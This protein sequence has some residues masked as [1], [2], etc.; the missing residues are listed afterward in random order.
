MVSE[1]WYK[2]AVIYCIDVDNFQDSDGDGCGDLVGLTSRLDYLARLGVTCLWLNPIHPSPQRDN[3]YDIS[4]YYAVD[5]RLGSLG[6]FV[7]LAIQARARGI[8]LLLD[9]VVNH[10]SDQHPW[11][12]SARSDPQSPYRDW[13]VWSSTEPA[14]RRQGMVFP[15]EQT[16][17]WTCDSV[18][19]QW[20]FHR[21]YDFQPDLNW[22][23]PAVRAEIKKVMAFWLQLGA[24]G[25]RIDAAP[26]VLEQ[27]SPDVDPGPLDFTILDDWRQDVQ[28][29]S[30]DAVLLC[31]ANVA[32]D[33][34][35][36]YC[37]AV[38]GG[39]N[40][41]AHMMFAFEL[42]AKLWL[43][44]ARSDAEPLVEYLGAMPRL[45]A[46]AQW[47]TF[48][49]NHDELDLSKLT[50][51]QRSDVM[52]AFAPKADMR[53]YNRGIRRRLAPMLSGDRRHIELAYSLQFTMP[54]TPILRYGEEIGMG[55][56]LNLKGRE[57]IRTPMQW[58]NGPTAGF[59]SA[60]PADLVRPVHKR[61][62][63]GASK[64]NVAAERRDRDSL[65]RWFQELISVLRECPEIGVGVPSVI[66]IALPRSVLAHRFDAPEGA[67]LLLHNL[68]AT[69]VTVDLSS[70]DIGKNPDEVFA[71]A[72]YEPLTR[73]LSQF[74]LDGW[75]YRWLRLRRNN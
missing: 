6:D 64:V 32:A 7:E 50:E 53:I 40:D 20:Y 34:L 35:P 25:F 28:W 63:Y 16:E 65:L 36:K 39:P 14:D 55:E 42:N 52:A 29:H 26:F 8:R 59:S 12:R 44:L 13:Y 67:I 41:R 61:G 74:F 71:N 9:L 3:G 2:E 54:G 46:M 15:G 18:A 49:R 22:S 73:D 43:S 56:D 10:T 47:A 58:D 17:T 70:V 38:A 45:P 60:A 21:F 66:D 69:P 68:A 33:D 48:L 23:N 62:S 30:G 51:E 27:V 72:A 75:G 4:D 5:A 11:F 19:K 24:S 1:R 31:E 37:A 57:S